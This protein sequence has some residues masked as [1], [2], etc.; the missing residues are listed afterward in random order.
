MT[1]DN[2]PLYLAIKAY[3]GQIYDMALLYELYFD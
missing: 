3:N 2:A 1:K